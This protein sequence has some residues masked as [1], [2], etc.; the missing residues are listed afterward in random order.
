MRATVSYLIGMMKLTL[1]QDQAIQALT[2][3]AVGAETFDR[4]FAG[5]RFDKLDGTMLYAFAKD[6][7][8]A[9]DIEDGY[10]IYIATVASRV[11]KRQVD[12]VVVMPKVLQ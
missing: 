4:L 7:E 11:L 1:V 8:I 10:S 2:A 12:V 5:I 3:G 9:S 6:E